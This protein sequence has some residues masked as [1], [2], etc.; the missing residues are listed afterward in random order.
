MSVKALGEARL[1]LW[2]MAALPLR[3]ELPWATLWRAW[4]GSGP[5]PRAASHRRTTGDG[6]ARLQLAC[7]IFPSSTVL[8]KFFLLAFAPEGCGR[9]LRMLMRVSAGCPARHRS[10]W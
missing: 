4:L 1:S 5:G 7:A 10:C 3:R 2:A 9:F 6:H 8:G